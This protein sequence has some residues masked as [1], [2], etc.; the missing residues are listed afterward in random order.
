[1]PKRHHIFY[2]HQP[3]FGI[4][5]SVINFSENSLLASKYEFNYRTNTHECELHEYCHMPINF[6]REQEEIKSII[7]LQ[8]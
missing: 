8:N 6:A 2:D 1:M 7:N 5:K 4:K 3:R